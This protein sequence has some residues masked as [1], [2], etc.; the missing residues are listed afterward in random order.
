MPRVIHD[1]LIFHFLFTTKALKPNDAK[2][3][4]AAEKYQTTMLSVF[5]PTHSTTDISATAEIYGKAIIRRLFP[6]LFLIK[7]RRF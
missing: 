3:E 6:K 1:L 5:S 4:T 2:A 7:F